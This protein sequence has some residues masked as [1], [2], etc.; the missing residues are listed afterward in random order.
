MLDPHTIRKIAVKAC[1]DPRTVVAALEGRASKLAT[2]A[3]TN[4]MRE[5][6]IIVP[7]D[8]RPPPHEAA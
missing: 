2:E 3:V 6:G 8:S 4:A 5:L 1:R 7:R